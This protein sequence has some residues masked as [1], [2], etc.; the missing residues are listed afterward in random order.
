MSTSK[1]YLRLSP[2]LKG[3]AEWLHYLLDCRTNVI[4]EKRCI[5]DV[6][7]VYQYNYLNNVSTLVNCPRLSTYQ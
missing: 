6:S 5:L 1:R 3:Q 7:D 2:H 4:S